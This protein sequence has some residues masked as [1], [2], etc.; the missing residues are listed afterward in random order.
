MTTGQSLAVKTTKG[1][2]TDSMF[3]LNNITW[4]NNHHNGQKFFQRFNHDGSG[5][6]EETQYN[7]GVQEY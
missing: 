4:T 7:N 6:R 2:I 3:V 1:K 5:D